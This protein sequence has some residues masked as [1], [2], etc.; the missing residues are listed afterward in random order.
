[1]NEQE[2]KQA[3]IKLGFS[4][5]ERFVREANLFNAEHTHEFDVE[6][7]ILDGELSVTTADGTSVCTA[8]DRYS[9]SRGIPHEEL[10][11]PSGAELLVAKRQ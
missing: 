7:Y 8:G 11:G 5:P 1:M 3:V 9:L 2:F 10:Y 4:E 6:A